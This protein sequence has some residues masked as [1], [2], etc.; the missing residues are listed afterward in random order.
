MN[1]SSTNTKVKKV[2]HSFAA[3]AAIMAIGML[4]VKIAGAAFK[5]PLSYILGGVGMGYF[6]TAYTMYSPIHALA[7]AGL[8]IAISRMVSG[9]MAQKRYKDVKLMHK[10]SIPIFI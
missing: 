6:M 10:I 4:I 3:G 1:N 9:Y 5:I 2:K 7:T 8:P